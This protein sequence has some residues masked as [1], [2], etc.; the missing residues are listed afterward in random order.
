MRRLFRDDGLEGRVKALDKILGVD[1]SSDN[2]MPL[3]ALFAR[4]KPK[5]CSEASLDLDSL[6][7]TEALWFV[8]YVTLVPQLF[9]A[10][11]NA[12]GDDNCVNCIKM[13]PK[14]SD[15]SISVALGLPPNI[16]LDD[17]MCI[18]WLKV[19]CIQPSKKESTMILTSHCSMT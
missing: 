18:L 17:F 6:K 7:Y 19:S 12:T 3:P 9:D 14:M 2:A 8:H 16:S 11:V 15:S 1:F 5:H 13:I 4:T 10:I